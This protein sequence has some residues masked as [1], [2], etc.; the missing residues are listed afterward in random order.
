VKIAFT[1]YCDSYS[2]VYAVNASGTAN[3]G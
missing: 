1:N 2:D 3:N